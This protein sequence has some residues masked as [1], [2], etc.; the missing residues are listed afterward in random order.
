MSTERSKA[1]P[2]SDRADWTMPG[3]TH[4]GA[5]GP[6]GQ[7]GTVAVTAFDHVLDR[8]QRLGR[9]ESDADPYDSPPSEEALREARRLLGYVLPH[10]PATPEQ[11]D[12]MEITPIG[13]GGIFLAWLGQRGEAQLRIRANGEVDGLFVDLGDPEPRYEER[14]D[15]TTDEAVR[16]VAR[17]FGGG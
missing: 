8:L 7:E 13:N 1:D 16:L 4:L 5:T 14:H 9:P 3:S 6:V 15:I 12:P 17:A 10:V 2:P 11:I